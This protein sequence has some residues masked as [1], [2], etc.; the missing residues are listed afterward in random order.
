MMTVLRRM[1]WLALLGGAGFAGWSA[2]QRRNEVVGTVGTPVWPP[3]EATTATPS[4]ADD[5]SSPPA[6][7]QPMADLADPPTAPPGAE[8]EGDA[9]LVDDG[10]AD[11][12]HAP[13]HR[14]VAPVDGRCPE[15]FPIKANDNSGIF[16]VPGGRFYERTIP[17]R[18]Y[19]DAADAEADGYRRAKA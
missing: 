12:S 14:W 13:P 6:A 15:G 10:T 8:T 9:E 7:V 3:F 18:C 2:W 4:P 11:A 19:A 1:F 16:H 5:A 17:E